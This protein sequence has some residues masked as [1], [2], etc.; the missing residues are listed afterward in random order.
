MNDQLQKKILIII[1]FVYAIL[2]STAITFIYL[3]K[4]IHLYSLSQN[5]ISYKIGFVENGLLGSIIFKIKEFLNLHPTILISAI[6][7][8]LHI[9]NLGLFLFLINNFI[10]ANFL[11]GIFLILNPILIIFPL[12]DFG[13]IFRKEAFIIFL[14]LLHFLISSFFIEKKIS[15]EV[16]TFLIKFLI[17]P[18]LIINCLIYNLQFLLIPIH[19]LIMKNNL[20]ISKK[21]L[22]I[23]VFFFS[24][25]FFLIQYLKI[26]TGHQY[27]YELTQILIGNDLQIEIAPFLWLKN[28]IYSSIELTISEVSTWKNLHKINLITNYSI[29]L[30]VLSGPFIFI[31]A[32][33]NFYNKSK[34]LN[35][36]LIYSSPSLAFFFLGVDWGRW[37]HIIFIT[38]VMYFSQFKF[39]KIFISKIYYFVFMIMI[40]LFSTSFGVPHCCAKNIFFYGFWRNV[41]FIFE[42]FS[43]NSI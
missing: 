30:L 7:L 17:I 27:L 9:T 1:F 32:H 22:F 25:Y 24:L 6:Y 41:K 37:F 10:R 14:L 34:H 18:G 15:K 19:I 38:I 2:F 26:K 42:I 36:L 43:I 39:E 20:M 4:N 8:S 3:S 12:Y 28:N 31:F 11:I 23:I 33:L 21:N 40:L 13:A 5:I 35:K 29:A 16:Y